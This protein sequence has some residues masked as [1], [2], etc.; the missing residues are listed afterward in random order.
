MRWIQAKSIISAKNGINL[1]RGC[2][3][4][5]IYCDSRSTVYQVGLFEDI[6]VKEHAL[7][8]TRKELSSKKKRA[9]ITTGSMCD[10][11]LHLEKELKLTQGMLKLI[12]EFGFGV[13][14]LTKSVLAMSTAVHLQTLKN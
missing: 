2:S 11:Y 5:C 10:P 8:M 12:N 14:S 7:S 1:Y 13:G 9:V 6:A 4:S 3:H